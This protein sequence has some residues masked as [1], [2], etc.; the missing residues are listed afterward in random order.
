[1]P[2]MPFWAQAAA[3]WIARSL[4]ILVLTPA[5]LVTITPLLVRFHLTPPEKADRGLHLADWTVGEAIEIVGLSLG[6]MILGLVLAVWQVRAESISLHLWGVNL[7]LV[8]WAGLRQGLRGG[9][10][11]AGSGSL[12]ALVAVS[13]GQAQGINSFQGLMLA[14]CSTALLVGGSAGVVPARGRRER[15]G[16]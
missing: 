3:L 15:P 2:A 5:L 10:L 14:Q 7:L 8:V 16:G 11:V 6:A 1:E 13:V 9:A 4:G 12:I